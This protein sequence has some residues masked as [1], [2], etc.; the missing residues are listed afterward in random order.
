[1]AAD[2]KG[3]EALLESF[4]LPAQLTKATV[5]TPRTDNAQ[6]GSTAALQKILFSSVEALSHSSG[7]LQAQ[8][9]R[10][11]IDWC[12]Q[13]VHGADVRCAPFP[14]FIAI[15]LPFL[16]C[17]CPT[18]S[19]PTKPVACDSRMGSVVFLV[20]ATALITGTGTGR[21]RVFPPHPADYASKAE[22]VYMKQL[23]EV[24]ASRCQQLVDSRL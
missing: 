20:G 8:L 14:F 2:V 6:V 7:M 13:Y 15:F 9:V 5:Q 19:G 3:A 21:R 1:M 24:G 11:S 22:M 23:A 18:A 16:F 17:S 10:G 4:T 12:I